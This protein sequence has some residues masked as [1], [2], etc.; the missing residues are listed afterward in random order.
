MSV[1]GAPL[2]M[3]KIMREAGPTAIATSEIST[4]PS[5]DLFALNSK[6]PILTGF[7][8]MPQQR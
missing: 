1:A 5:I 4:D 6:W 2:V 8:A 7:V 3:P